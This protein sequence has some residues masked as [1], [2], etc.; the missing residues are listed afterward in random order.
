MNKFFISLFKKYI[1]VFIYTVFIFHAHGQHKKLIDSL[2][3]KS[4]LEKRRIFYGYM[5]SEGPLLFPKQKRAEY[6]AVVEK[7]AKENNEKDLLREIE[8]VRYKKKEVYD[9]PRSQ[10]HHKLNLL[11]EK[12]KK[13]NNLLFLI[14]CYHENGGIAF[15]L[16]NYQEAFEIY[17]KCLEAINKIGP[18]NVPNLGKNLHE[19]SL[20]YYFF[21]DYKQVIKLMRMSIKYPPFSKGLDIQRYN[22]LGV[23]Y[24]KLQKVDSANY[25][26]T[27]ALKV[28]KSYNS[29]TWEGLIYAN[30]GELYFDQ[31][32]YDSSLYFY[33]KSY[34]INLNEKLSATIKLNSLINMAKIHLQLGDLT[35]TKSFLDQAAVLIYNT[36]E[37]NFGDKQLIENSKLNYFDIKIKYLMQINEFKTA[38]LYKDSAALGKAKLDQ[39]YN[40]AILKISE[41]QI[42]IS[43][44]QAELI[45]N[46]NDKKKQ[47]ILYITIVLILLCVVAIGF[48]YMHRYKIKKTKQSELLLLQNKKI[49]LEKSQAK[50]EL[51]LAR[52][53]MQFFV[54]KISEQ[55]N[56]VLKLKEDLSD[57]KSSKLDQAVLNETLEKLEDVRILTDEDWMNFQ[58]KFKKIHPEFRSKIKKIS[59]TITTSEIRYLMLTQLKFSH[60]EM[61]LAL[62]IS[63]S[64]M[65]VTWNRVRKRLNAKT[66]DTPASLLERILNDEGQL[67]IPT[68]I[69]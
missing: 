3:G 1:T 8:F 55:N 67:K 56:I 51:E 18:E 9:F 19:I 45:Q 43:N 20:Q 69:Q 52:K 34:Q 60:K 22:N 48:Y 54:S 59:P 29:S 63:S 66:E 17:I 36:K 61:A 33:E 62:G 12:Y 64:S 39:T 30:L 28:A 4:S 27:K 44:T 10:W 6:L 13:E 2:A 26:F 23:S 21:K 58:K 65:R 14:Y 57:A 41:K 49:T 42:T 31:K 25:F 11:T 7:Y 5:E 37:K 35:K 50:K 46:E 16:E 53:E 32:K 15:D 24:Q 47:S 68:V 40:S 38:L